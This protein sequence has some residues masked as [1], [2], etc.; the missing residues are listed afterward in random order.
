[1]TAQGG[2]LSA[3]DSPI[4][5]VGYIARSEHRAL[6]LVAL[7]VRPRSRSELWELTGVSS[8]TIRRTLREFETRNW[9]RRNGYRYETTQLGAF[10]TDAMEGLIERIETERELRD[11]WDW[12]PSEES[13]FTVEM[14]SDA[15]VTVAKPDDPYRPVN[16]F[17]SLLGRTNEFRF[18]G[19]DVALLEPCKDV[20]RQRI[21]DGMETEIVDPPSGAKY[22]LSTYPDHC[23]EP[24][25]SGNLSVLSHDELPPYGIGF[26]DDRIAVSCNDQDSGTV[27]ALI[28]TDAPSAREWAESTYERYRSEARPLES[29]VE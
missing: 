16:R 20:L 19:F 9:I 6:A 22:I 17:T 27:R 21:V 12:F 7:S 29:V 1:M 15:V 14:C 24:L 11:V 23:A 18:V 28:D 10:V 8:S 4:D 3:A 13:G 5:D 26:F 2:T 25:E